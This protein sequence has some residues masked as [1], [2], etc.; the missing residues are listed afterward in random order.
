MVS[1]MKTG[2]NEPC[3]CGSGKKFKRCCIG[4]LESK[5]GEVADDIEQILAMNPNLSLDELNVVAQEKANQRNNS[6]NDDFMGLTPTQIYNWLYS[7]LDGL[8]DVTINTPADLSA[9][10]V[11]CYLALILDEALENGGSFKATA[12]GNLPAKLV[13]K[14]SDLLPKFALA[15]YTT[16]ISISEFAGSNEDKFNA[17]HYTR[18]LAELSGIVKP[19]NGCYQVSKKT[20]EQYKKKGIN[21]FFKTMLQTAVHQY[22][23]GYMDLWMDADDLKLFWLFMLW[24]LQTHCNAERLNEE[25]V[26]AFPALLE[27]LSTEEGRTPEDLLAILIKSRFIERFLEYW[28]FVVL[29]PKYFNAETGETL[30]LNIELQPLLKQTFQFKQ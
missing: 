23:W 21:A 25:V 1:I 7:P 8:E 13:K 15:K 5:Q 20:M 28:G 27:Q 2:R 3:P 17:L 6:A 29:D 19:K 4:A 30:P 18:V 24:R 26:K 10:P 9:S 14:A 12:K 16:H 22:N 11:M